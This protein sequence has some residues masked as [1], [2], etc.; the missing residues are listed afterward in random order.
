MLLDANDSQ[1]QWL[2]HFPSYAGTRN[3]IR[4]TGRIFQRTG[5]GL[6]DGTLGDYCRRMKTFKRS[7]ID[8]AIVALFGAHENNARASELKRRI[9]RLLQTDR[10]GGSPF[11]FFPKGDLG[12]GSE[13]KFSAYEA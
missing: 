3:W 7:Q 8:D 9:T 5:A 1:Y 12:S 2:E 13:A 4:R 11:A 10:G 6:V